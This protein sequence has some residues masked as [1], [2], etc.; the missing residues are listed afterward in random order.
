M[1]LSSSPERIPVPAAHP[2]LVSLFTHLPLRPAS[3]LR[4]LLLRVLAALFALSAAGMLFY[5]TVGLFSHPSSTRPAEQVELTAQLLAA[6][7][8]LPFGASAPNQ[9]EED[10]LPSTAAPVE[11]PSGEVR[12]VYGLPEDAAPGPVTLYRLAEDVPIDAKAFA[13]LPQA[14]SGEGRD[15]LSV[16]PF[17]DRELAGERDPWHL[18]GGS[19]AGAAALWLTLFAGAALVSAILVHFRKAL[20][21]FEL[22]RARREGLVLDPDAGRLQWARLQHLEGPWSFLPKAWAV[23]A[24]F[25][26][27]LSTMALVFGYF[28]AGDFQW[29]LAAAFSASLVALF[30]ALVPARLGARAAVRL[31]SRLL[32]PRDPLL[33]PAWVLLVPAGGR[34]LRR[35]RRTLSPAGVET[36]LTFAAEQAVTLEELESVVSAL[37]PSPAR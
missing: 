24:F 11:L 33:L 4:Q 31:R 29:A 27:V 18:V 28:S 6:P 21:G 8:L 22:Y 12:T 35:L 34:H 9:Y 16:R 14:V 25:A 23:L 30:L 37:E 13:S 15:A 7:D 36:A 2:L 3:P 17:P 1:L 19:W 32:L 26:T 5:L 20:E 10:P